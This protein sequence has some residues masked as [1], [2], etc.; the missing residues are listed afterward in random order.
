M[1]GISH[2]LFEKIRTQPDTLFDE[3]SLTYPLSYQLA[4]LIYNNGRGSKNLTQKGSHA[5]LKASVRRAADAKMTLQEFL[6][7]T[8]VVGRPWEEP[9]TNIVRFDYYLKCYRPIFA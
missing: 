1:L 5:I 7:N 9:R 4:Y 3:F 8:Q 6:L 2:V